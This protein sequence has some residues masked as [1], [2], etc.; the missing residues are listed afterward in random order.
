MRDYFW[1]HDLA[2][3][4]N[5]ERVKDQYLEST[6]SSIITSVLYCQNFDIGNIKCWRPRVPNGRFRWILFDQDYGFHLW[7]PEVYLPAMARDYS[8]YDAYVRFYTNPVGSSISWPNSGG[9]TL[10]LRGLLANPDFRSDFI[11]RCA[12]L[13]N[14]TFRSERGG[15][16]LV[17][18]GGHS[19]RDCAAPESLELAVADRTRLRRSTP[20]DLLDRSVGGEHPGVDR[21]R[22]SASG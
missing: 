1:S 18:G 4:Q 3:P 12:D 19:T 5:Y 21:L 13:L 20:E 7:P 2:A 11:N 16:D 15:H 8:D 6:I 14:S 10:L 9:I 17:D 22:A